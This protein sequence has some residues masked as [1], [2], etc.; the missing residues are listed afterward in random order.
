MSQDEQD[1]RPE[2]AA[3]TPEPP[4]EAAPDPED[5]ET[6][7]D[8]CDVPIGDDEATPDEE[9]PMTEGGVL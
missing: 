4:H 7:V 2:G 1:A 9:L 8:G 5:D 6:D 3:M